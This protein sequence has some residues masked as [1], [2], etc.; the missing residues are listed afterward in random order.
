MV[1]GWTIAEAVGQLD[2][3]IPRRELARR[4][5]GVRACGK[6]YGRKG[7]KPKV[8]PIAAIFQAHAEWV[9]GQRER[10]DVGNP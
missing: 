10:S 8:Y 6:R 2:P 4:L 9:R 7:R 1:D 5:A 3:P